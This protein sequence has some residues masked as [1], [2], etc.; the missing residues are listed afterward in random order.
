MAH[1]ILKEIEQE[2]FSIDNLI[3]N[4]TY[5]S[6][7]GRVGQS[8]FDPLILEEIFKR[9]IEDLQKINEKTQQKID[10]LESD[11]LNEKISCKDKIASLENNYKDSYNHL[12]KL[13]TNISTIST[14]MS[15]MGAQ[16]ENLNKP[17]HNLSESQ[18]IAKYF[19]KFMEGTEN[20]GVFADD[21]KLEHAAEIIYK[22]HLLTIDLN[23]SRFEQASFL[24]EKKYSETETKIIERFRHAYMDGNKIMMKKY[25]MILSNFKGYQNC[26]NMFIKNSQ[27]SVKNSNNL[28]TELVPLCRR[29]NEMINEVFSNNEKIME[30]FVKDLFLTTVKDFV[31]ANIEKYRETDL[32]RYL[33]TIYRYYNLNKKIF[34]ELSDM[35]KLS[36]ESSFF[37][38][39]MNEV[40]QSHLKDYVS[41]EKINL[42]NKFK[43][44]LDRFYDSIGHTKTN[45]QSLISNFLSKPTGEVIDERFLSH[46]VTTLSIDD[47]KKSLTRV[48]LLCEQ[49]LQGKAIDDIYEI[50]C[51]YLCRDHIIYAI[52]IH[53]NALKSIDIKQ[54]INLH[55]FPLIKQLN[56]LMYLFEQFTNSS[57]LEAT[58]SSSYHSKIIN[59]Q[60]H[61]FLEIETKI[62]IGLEKAFMVINNNIKHALQTEQKRTDFKSENDEIS[63]Q[64]TPACAKAIRIIENQIAKLNTCL[65][66]RNINS[67]LKELGMKYHRC[68]Y[69]HLF[70]FEYNELGAMAVI[71]DINEYRLCAKN[72]NS[73]I[74][75]RLFAVLWALSNLLLVKPA[76]LQEI[77]S[78]DPLIL[79][80]KETLESFVQ[81]R[82]DYKTL[83]FQIPKTK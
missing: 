53:T 51:T 22:L 74:V 15:E 12:A 48:L 64:C 77:C 58:R 67:A 83:K 23:D 10:H 35:M 13:D 31:N 8:N 42:T 11:C 44:Q 76:N 40:Y 38:K 46:D 24:I 50:I 62:D 55:I 81:L 4:L 70:K 19:D 45:T 30:Q 17:R 41:L 32:E 33:D 68:I 65:D 71:R 54:E 20:S 47:A 59:R 78:E 21:S 60:R 26:I 43:N 3:E 7:D 28:F 63:N 18:K 80:N 36:C 9:T 16:L 27:M 39:L 61:I 57:V 29:T 6:T 82:S 73:P 37:A 79:L 72:F 2:S 34:K 52:D 5:K 75:D 14:T 49:N 69:D 56:I 25:L 66:G 1:L